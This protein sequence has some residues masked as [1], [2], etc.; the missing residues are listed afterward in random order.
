MMSAAP[1]IE[2]ARL[3]LRA[4]RAAD[5]EAW[6]PFARSERARFVGGPYDLGEAWRGFAHVVGHWVLRGFGMFVF[7]P[8][9]SDAAMGMAGPWF[10][11]DWPEPEIAWSLWRPEDEGKGYA[12]EAA[13]AARAHAFGPLGW[14]TAVSYVDPAN[15]RSMRLAERLGA[16]RDPAAETPG[17]A[18]CL[19]YRHAANGGTA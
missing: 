12:F 10:P 14:R 4:P 6:A 5:W 9:G 17:D 7:A 2:T 19:V 18:T 16:R 1:M 3:Q 15:T 13:Q 8:K 11:A